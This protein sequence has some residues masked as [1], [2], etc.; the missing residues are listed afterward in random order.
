VTEV[1]VGAA[2]AGVEGGDTAV[3]T[4]VDGAGDTV[5]V[6]GTEEAAGTTPA[7]RGGRDGAVRTELH[8]T[9]YGRAVGW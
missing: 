5:T 7:G 1:W 4:A 3:L 8:Q 2:L 9:T 6:P